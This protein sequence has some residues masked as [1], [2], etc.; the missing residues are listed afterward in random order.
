MALIS[1]LASKALQ[2]GAAAQPEQSLLTVCLEEARQGTAKH[3]KTPR[4]GENHLFTFVTVTLF[5]HHCNGAAHQHLR[6]SL[7][8][9]WAA[10]ALQTTCSQA[11]RTGGTELLLNRESPGL[12]SS[13]MLRSWKSTSQFQDDPF[14]PQLP[15]RKRHQECRV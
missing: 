13:S 12:A 8:G 7:G 6:F 11:V 1:S 9:L 10:A 4:T 3:S 5:E 14:M 2:H 15:E